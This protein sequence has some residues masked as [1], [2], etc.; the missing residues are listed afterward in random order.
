M[1]SDVVLSSCMLLIRHIS[2]TWHTARDTDE[3]LIVST[4]PERRKWERLAR[5]SCVPGVLRVDHLLDC[6]LRQE[7]DLSQGMLE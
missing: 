2:H 4:E 1:S 6:I 5:L 3:V 7:L